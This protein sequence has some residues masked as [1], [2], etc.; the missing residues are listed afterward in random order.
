MSNIIDSIQVSGVT[1]TL[2]GSGGGGTVSGHTFYTKYGYYGSIY[3][4]TNGLYITKLNAKW[5][6][7][8]TSISSTGTIFRDFYITNDGGT[9]KEEINVG[10]ATSSLGIT[11]ITSTTGSHFTATL[12]DGVVNVALDDGY[13]IYS[14]DT[15]FNGATNV[16]VISLCVNVVE[17]GDTSNVLETGMYETIDDALNT[18]AINPVTSVTSSIEDNK[19]TITSYTQLGNTNGNKRQV[20]LNDGKTIQYTSSSGLSVY[21]VTDNPKKIYLNTGSSKK[22]NVYINDTNRLINELF[23]TAN[24]GYTGNVTSEYVVVSYAYYSGSTLQ[25]LDNIFFYDASNHAWSLEEL[26][27][28]AATY[29]TDGY[30][31]TFT[32]SNEYNSYAYEVYLGD[33]RSLIAGID[34]ADKSDCMFDGVG[35]NTYNHN[36]QDVIDDIYD[37]LDNIPSGGGTPTVELTQAEYDALV[38]AGTVSA[39][40]YYIITDAQPTDISQY[41]TSAQTQSAINRA[42]SGKVDSSSVVTAVTSGSTDSEIPTAK[43]VYAVTSGGTGGGKAISAGTNISVTTGETADTV[44]CTLPIYYTVGFKSIKSDR[45]SVSGERN[46][47]W[48]NTAY[49]GRKGSSYTPDDAF[50]FGY[51]VNA[52]N[53]NEASF[54]KYN[55]SN[56]NTLVGGVSGTTLFS[57][58]NGT[59]DNAR[60]NAFEIR[61]NGDIYCNNGTSDV[62]VQDYLQ[63]KIV[64]LTQAQYTALSPNYDANTVYFIVD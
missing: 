57:V 59:A 26:A 50:A 24:S 49:V 34:R 33:E 12:S 36:G 19:L 16:I 54:G 61:Q 17:S 20:K 52:Y 14:V 53:S 1:Y 47:A 42:T 64:K 11:A 51:Y 30:T 40:T 35:Y 32:P 28:T 9:T 45:A 31:L 2:Q 43:A 23:I 39:N 27:D 7:H 25:T 60:H 4:L 56:Q 10:V 46:I 8:F 41:W 3:P 13:Y 18:V 63:F 6:S 15:S 29:T 21:F 44:N 55:V 62:K 58:G 38:S 37:K 48:G 22:Y 5:D